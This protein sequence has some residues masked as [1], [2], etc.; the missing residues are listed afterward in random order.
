MSS[1]K[2]VGVITKKAFTL[3]ADVGQFKKNQTFVEGTPE[4]ELIQGLRQRTLALDIEEDT[5]ADVLQAAGLKDTYKTREVLKTLKRKGMLNVVASSTPK[6]VSPGTSYRHRLLG[7]NLWARRNPDKWYKGKA[8]KPISVGISKGYL[9]VI[10]NL[11][12]DHTNT[13][14]VV[15]V[16]LQ[17]I[18]RFVRSE[19][20][21]VWG[22]G[23][24]RAESMANAKLGPFEAAID[25]KAIFEQL[26]YRRL[27]PEGL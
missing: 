2:R 17:D 1:P 5:L 13:L 12:I 6:Q 10:L 16:A 19:G 9:H 7:L 24:S 14:R 26:L 3:L 11:G 4:F 25:L 20:S 18:P 15:S 8:F 23:D 21:V 27:Y 22:T